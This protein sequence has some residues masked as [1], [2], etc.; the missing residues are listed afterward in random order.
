MSIDPNESREDQWVLAKLDADLSADKTFTKNVEKIER[1]QAITPT[2]KA[3]TWVNPTLERVQTGRDRLRIWAPGLAGTAVVGVVLI[4]PGP[5]DIP[6]TGPLIAYGIAF[7]AFGW[8]TA[9]GRPGPRD[10]AALLMRAG[11][12]MARWIAVAAVA[13]AGAT[14]KA[15]RIV[16]NAASAPV[17]RART[18]EQS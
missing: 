1:S 13:V 17:R 6:L 9:A 8:W 12:T 3:E 2:N 10:S 14:V 11:T 4:G 7:A 18:A 5:L 15:G 16:G